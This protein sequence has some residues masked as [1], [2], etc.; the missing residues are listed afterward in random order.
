MKGISGCCAG[1]GCTRSAGVAG[2]RGVPG[3]W[4]W[5]DG[6]G[7]SEVFSRLNVSIIA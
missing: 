3:M 5:W 7:N 6:L 2:P 1:I 4:A